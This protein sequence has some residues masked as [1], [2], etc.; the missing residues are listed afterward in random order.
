M[1]N[2]YEILQNAQDGQALDNLAK[3]FNI[4]KEEAD[5]AAKELL[6]ALSTGFLS[7]ASEPGALGPILGAL[8]EGQHLAAFADPAAAQ[9]LATAQKGDEIL[10]HLFGSNQVDEQ[11]VQ[12]ASAATGLAPELLAQMLPVIASVIS[13]G[14]TKSL[15]GQGFG[16]IF[17]QLVNA[18]R[19]GGLSSILGPLTEGGPSASGPQPR[20]GLEPSQAP[21]G[22]GGGLGSILGQ[23][24]RAGAS[25]SNPAQQGTGP[26]PSTS[27]AGGFGAILGA[28]IGNLLGRPGAP[29]AAPAPTSPAP[30]FD[31]SAIQA[32]LEAL[33]KILQPGTP[34]PTSRA[35]LASE[36]EPQETETPRAEPEE[37]GR[38]ESPSHTDQPHEPGPSHEL[39]DEIGQIL[40]GKGP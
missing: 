19:Q 23:L 5:A 20:P 7:K 40:D 22:A 14:V 33:T 28:L 17:T 35:I 21:A 31:A 36:I 15:Q 13:G 29:T 37:I 11:V 24:L 10:V 30:G 18:A 9:S 34:P 8:S 26:G 6:P 32:G 39:R 16:G 12:R 27:A 25:S 2:L 38:T 1:S 3:Q 4:S